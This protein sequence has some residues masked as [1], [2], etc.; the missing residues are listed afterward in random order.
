[1]AR[2]LRKVSQAELGR[3][4]DRS[5]ISIANIE[6]GR[7]GVSLSQVFVLADALNANVDELIPDRKSIYSLERSTD[8]AFVEF[9][10]AR[11]ADLQGG[12]G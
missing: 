10:K 12:N 7:H 6:S 9:A 1:M 4:I 8:D 3:R 11:L 2:R 5:R